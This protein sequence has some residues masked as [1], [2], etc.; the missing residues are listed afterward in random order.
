MSAVVFTS[1]MIIST[2]NY[3]ITYLFH[4]CC[5]I[6]YCRTINDHVW[7]RFTLVRVGYG[8]LIHS[9]VGDRRQK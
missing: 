1:V 5:A 8:M 3:G 4:D 6:A 2:P 7:P 9:T